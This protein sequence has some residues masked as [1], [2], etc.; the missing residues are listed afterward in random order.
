MAGPLSAGVHWQEIRKLF[1]KGPS[2]R[3]I[4]K[5]RPSLLLS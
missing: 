2:K 5:L 3:E 1:G 4:A